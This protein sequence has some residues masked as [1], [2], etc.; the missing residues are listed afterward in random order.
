M[1]EVVAVKTVRGGKQMW[2][3]DVGTHLV[4]AN[5]MHSGQEGSLATGNIV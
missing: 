5:D 3:A 2:I 1:N 4:Q